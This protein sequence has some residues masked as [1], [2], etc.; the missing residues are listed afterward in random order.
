MRKRRAVV[1][2][3]EE[4]LVNLLKEFFSTRGYAVLPFTTPV[5]CPIRDEKGNFCKTDYPCADVIITDFK[6]PRTNGLE[7]L[8]EQSR[9][10]CKVKSGNK[11]VMSGYLDEES[12]R[13]IQQRGYAFFQ[14]PIDFSKLSAWLDECEKRMDLSQ[15]LSSSRKETRHLTRYNVQCLVDSTDETVD[16]MTVDISNSGF[17]LKLATPLI[18]GQVIHISTRPAVIACRTA[19]VLWVN[20]NP[21]GSYLAGFSCH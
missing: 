3:D 19:S 10:G 7:L 17:C 6:M 9:H 11:A 21:D 5:V 15:P 1:I 16:G 12:Y 13:K 4:I 2:D 18:A 14:K 8:L 20:E